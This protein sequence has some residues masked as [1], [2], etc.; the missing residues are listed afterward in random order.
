MRPPE[1]PLGTVVGGVLGGAAGFFAGARFGA[2][3]ENSH[4]W[5]AAIGESVGL[6]VG[7]HV[8]NG[9]RGNLGEDLVAS[10]GVGAVGVAIVLSL[11]ETGLLL[12]PVVQVAA[13]ATTELTAG[14][15]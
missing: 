2:G 13:V 1:D 8:G 7:A 4:F 10:L 11:G 12:A 5:G 9:R 6:A 14:R 3:V 15:R